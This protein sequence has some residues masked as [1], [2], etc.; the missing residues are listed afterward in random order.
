[1]NSSFDSFFRCSR[2]RIFVIFRR[3]SARSLRSRRNGAH[4]LAREGEK[5]GRRE[6]K[7]RDSKTHRRRPSFSP[8]DHVCDAPFRQLL[9]SLAESPTFNK[10]FPENYMNGA[11]E[12]LVM[13]YE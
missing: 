1:M 6:K 4:C 8:F 12:T 9:S 13:N 10:K 3:D 11:C 2:W 5:E 7:C